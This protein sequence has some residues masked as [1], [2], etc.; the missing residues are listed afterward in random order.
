MSKNGVSVD[1]SANNV[2]IEDMSPQI[3]KGV[4]NDDLLA[5]LALYEKDSTKNQIEMICTPQN[6]RIIFGREMIDKN[7]GL[8]KLD[9]QGNVMTYSDKYL[10]DFSYAGGVLENYPLEKDKYL[11]LEEDCKYRCFGRQ[12][13]ITEFG[14]KR[15]LPIFSTIEPYVP[16]VQKVQKV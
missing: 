10:V 11:E 9:S 8:P 5:F 15:D 7:S 13:S 3:V 6:K 12:G 14:S 1:G 16:N 4:S 2:N